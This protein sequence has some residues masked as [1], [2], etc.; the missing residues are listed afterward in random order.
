MITLTG[1]RRST[2]AVQGAKY[3]YADASPEIMQKVARIELIC[4]RYEVPLSAATT[5]FPLGH[6]AVTSVVV[7]ADKAAHVAANITALEKTIPDEFWH[8]L[9]VEGLLI[10]YQ[11]LLEQADDV[12]AYH[13]VS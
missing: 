8:T 9:N 6:P 7:G 11:E 1:S 5:Q 4:R 12:E 3:N 2:G 13:R 10:D